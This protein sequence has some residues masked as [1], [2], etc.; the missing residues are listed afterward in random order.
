MRRNQKPGAWRAGDHLIVCDRSGMI[1]PRSQAR[2]EWNGLLVRKESW[3]QRHPQEYVRGVV[4]K[5]AT[6]GRPWQDPE[7]TSTKS[8]SD[9][10]V[11]SG[12]VSGGTYTSG[13]VTESYPFVFWT[14]DLGDTRSLSSI[15][16]SELRWSAQPPIPVAEGIFLET[17]KWPDDATWTRQPAPLAQF[18]RTTTGATD[19]TYP[20]VADGQRFVRLVL[21][22]EKGLGFSG[23]LTHSS[24][25]IKT[26]ATQAER[27]W[28]GNTFWDQVTPWQSE[29]LW[30]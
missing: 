23:T 2:R 26:T 1:V 30:I 11:S 14:L 15:T 19:Y 8:L 6:I 21:V 17:R 20:L 27:E 22:A 9:I 3:E 12:S 5:Q 4:D 16:I 18:E 29:L 24:I 13:A 25:S 10:V 28:V 7:K